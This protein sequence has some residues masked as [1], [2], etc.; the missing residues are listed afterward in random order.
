MSEEEYTE[1][2]K[3]SDV[4]RTMDCGDNSCAFATPRGGMRTNGGCR[5]LSKLQIHAA[6][7]KGWVIPR[8]K[9]AIIETHAREVREKFEAQIAR[10]DRLMAAAQECL[11][12]REGYWGSEDSVRKN[13][14]EYA[15]LYDAL[16]AYRN[17]GDE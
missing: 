11:E 6:D 9:H 1:Q 2:M 5:C 4:T 3:K 13:Q 14:S 7:A 10:G 8:S 17:G 15:A 12:E 16:A